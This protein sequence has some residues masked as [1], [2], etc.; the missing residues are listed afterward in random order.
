MCECVLVCVNLFLC[1]VKIQ[2]Y[3]A[4]VRL[5]IF[6][7]AATILCNIGQNENRKVERK[8]RYK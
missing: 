1:H 4:S 3:I 7:F 5:S 2:S 8:G 6:L